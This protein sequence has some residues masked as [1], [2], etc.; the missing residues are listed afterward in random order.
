MLPG[1]ARRRI[2]T[3]FSDDPGIS[4]GRSFGARDDKSGGGPVLQRVPSR[5]LSKSPRFME[6]LGD[7][8]RSDPELARPRTPSRPHEAAPDPVVLQDGLPRARTPPRSPISRSRGVSPVGT[9]RNPE[10][11]RSRGVSPVGSQ[12]VAEEARPR[13]QALETT[14]TPTEALPRRQAVDTASKPTGARPR[15]VSPTAATRGAEA[16]PDPVVLQSSVQRVKTPPRSPIGRQRSVSP[17]TPARPP[18]VTPTPPTGSMPT[19]HVQGSGDRAW[20]PPASGNKSPTRAAA[21]TRTPN[22][23]GGSRASV[24][25]ASQVGAHSSRTSVSPSGGRA[26]D[27]TRRVTPPSGS[28]PAPQVTGLNLSAGDRRALP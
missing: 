6:G 3:D 4:R 15:G 8:W 12:R 25:S 21:P 14:S 10:I 1:S 22:Q 18:P 20:S 16:V 17:I 5:S 27:S 28:F 9:Q 2:E 24:L 23:G 7:A 26:P 11:P 13:G 19:F